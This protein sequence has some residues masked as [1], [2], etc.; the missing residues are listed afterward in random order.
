MFTN[1]TPVDA[2]RGAGRPEC[3][4]VIER[5][6]DLFAKEIGR[7]PVAVRRKNFIPPFRNGYE[8]STGVSYDSGNY[9]A[10]LNRALEML[11]Y[12]GFRTEQRQARREGRLIGVG[13]SSYIEICG[14][15][16]SAVAASL[17]AGAGLWESSTVRVHPTGKVAVYTGTSPHGQGHQTSFM[18]IT[19]SELGVPIEDVEVFHGDTD[20]QQ[21]GTGN[22]R[23]PQR[24]G[25]RDGSLHEPAEGHRQGQEDR[26]SPD[27]RAA[28]RQVT[29][30]NG[31]FYVED[32]RERQMSFGD[33][34]G[35]GLRGH[36]PAASHG[37]GTGSGNVLRPGRTSPGRSAPTSPSSR[38]IPT[39]ARRVCSATS[40]WT[41][42]GNV[43][44]PMI[45]DGMVHGGVAQGIGQA[46]QEQAV[47]SDNGQ[48][49]SGSMLDYAVPT[50]EDIPT[51]DTDR[52]VTPTNVNPL[53]VK[54]AGETGTIACSP[55]IVNA[56]VDALSHLGVR[57]MDMPLTSEKVWRTI[58]DAPGSPDGR[59]PGPRR[60][61]DDQLITSIAAPFAY[62]APSSVEEASR[63]L[64]RY[65]GNARLLAGGHSLLPL[66]KLRLASPDALIDLG[67]VDGL[68]GIRES[69]DGIAVGAMTTYAD[70]T[71]SDLVAEHAPA[72]AEAAAQVADTPVRNAGTIGG[73]VAHADP[74]GDLPA[75]VLAPGSA[76]TRAVRTRVTDN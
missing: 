15:A 66:M 36:Q 10:S 14:I 63:L 51:F 29:F 56:A 59:P 9:R 4:Y 3:T 24:C 5:L 16:P 45:V 71:R 60:R 50:A 2:Y 37:A 28:H 22:V 58:R 20:K 43:I 74:A 73:S 61:E 32:I 70:I 1:T 69:G 57:H 39:P 30:E 52:T 42:S 65:R 35:T 27:G 41:T 38:S 21:M 54:G 11:D 31:I 75:V 47:Y 7:D 12:R 76:D 13:L 18:Q 53:G 19:S 40:R 44:N 25:W 26:R 68:S 23:Q 55:A 17:G 62:H 34:V 64:S 6:V 49:L 8:V 46:L 72:L 33:V 67:R 48:L